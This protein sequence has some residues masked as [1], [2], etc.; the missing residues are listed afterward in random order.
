MFIEALED[1]ADVRCPSLLY[2]F[3][4]GTNIMTFGEVYL[5]IKPAPFIFAFVLDNRYNN[6]VS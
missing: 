1:N 6:K 2:G 5:G 4:N 3:D